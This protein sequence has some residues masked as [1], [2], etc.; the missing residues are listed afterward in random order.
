MYLYFRLFRLV[1]STNVTI[2]ANTM[3]QHSFDLRKVFVLTVLALLGLTFMIMGI[4]IS[5]YRC[6]VEKMMNESN[7]PRVLSDGTNVLFLPPE[8]TVH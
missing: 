6:H 2:L 4:S 5:I 7:L 8:R 3:I 1:L